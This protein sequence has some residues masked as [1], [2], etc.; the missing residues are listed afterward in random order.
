MRGPVIEVYVDLRNA[1]NSLMLDPMKIA[2]FHKEDIRLS[3]DVK[4]DVDILFQGKHYHAPEEY[5]D[6]LML[7]LMDENPVFE[8]PD[9]VVSENYFMITSYHEDGSVELEHR[10]DCAGLSP[11]D[12][13]LILWDTAAEVRDYRKEMEEVEVER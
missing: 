13:R 6:A 12:I 7:K 8:Y 1:W 3:L 5:P 10:V 9:E 11:T 2:E 4:G